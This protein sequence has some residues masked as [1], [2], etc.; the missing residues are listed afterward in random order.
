MRKTALRY[1]GGTLAALTAVG[2]LAACSAP[3]DT[4]DET[5]AAEG[6]L[7]GICP[8]PLVIQ[9]DWEPESEHGGIYELLGDDYEIDTNAKSVTGAMVLPDGS[10]AGI[11][12]EIRIGGAPVGYQPV[13]S[14][15]YQ[16]DSI[17]MGYGRVT[18]YMAV[19]EETPIVG[20]LASLEKSPYSIY[21]DPETYPDVTEIADLKDDNVTILMGSDASV[22][23]DYL[24]ARGIVAE[25]Q[26]DRS[27]APKP[28][29]FIAA[30]GTVAE[31]GFASAEPFLYEVESPEWSKP[32][33]VGLIHDTGYPEYFQTVVVREADV[34]ER[35]E[36][37]T[38]LVPIM[39]QAQV[40]YATDPAHTN[41][42]IVELVETYDTGWVYSAEMADWSIAQQLEL[43]L[44][45]NA[46]SGVMGEFDLD[47]V[48]TLID[49]VN[50]FTEYDVSALTP[51][52]LVTNEFIDTS[53]S[54]P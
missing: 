3:A 23:I 2:L 54:L 12:V 52:V 29:S 34:T 50:E 48:Q 26:V 10:P 4:P 39:Q 19:V 44:V 27:E 18:E 11:D 9:A 36:C 7:T 1:A 5:P 42:L 6:V 53:I 14:L 28:A 30:G 31:A 21:W 17:F 22:W 43:G 35:S 16:D 40:D 32:L 46:S 15:L 41:A 13:Q 47:R 37:L 20:V 38:A 33:E 45:A 8:N 49:L 25:S 51:D 24:L